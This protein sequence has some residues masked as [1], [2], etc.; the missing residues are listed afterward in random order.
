MNSIGY[1][2][3]YKA[4][5]ELEA[6]YG[7]SNVLKIAIAQVGADFMVFDEGR[8]ILLVEVKT[9][10]LN[11]WYA[12]EKEKIQFNKI[13]SF[14]LAHNCPA[15]LWIYYKQGKGNPMIKEIRNLLADS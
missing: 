11:K 7:S 5:K 13:K 6:I 4:K 2:G 8:L 1:S 3:E 10:T 12:R 15:E 14:A 9:T